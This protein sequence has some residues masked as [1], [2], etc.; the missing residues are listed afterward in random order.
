MRWMCEAKVATMMRPWARSK[1]SASAA[2]TSVSEGVWPGRSTLVESEQSTST[3]RS[4]S[5]VER[6]VVRRLAVER[7]GSS[8]K[9]PVWTMVPTGVSMAR[10]IPST[11]ECVTR[12]A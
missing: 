2:P 3:P 9:S 7:R 6:A 10:P 1:R 5:S 8:L 4:P 11:M 12:M